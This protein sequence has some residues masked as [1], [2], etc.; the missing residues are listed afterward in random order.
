[1]LF[2]TWLQAHAY[3][4]SDHIETRL[5]ILLYYNVEAKAIIYE[6]VNFENFLKKDHVPDFSHSDS[7]LKL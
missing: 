5:K 6:S 7:I 3:N 4:P 2:G 1:M